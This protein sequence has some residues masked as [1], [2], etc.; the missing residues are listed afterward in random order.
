MTE[1]TTSSLP[2]VTHADYLFYRCSETAA[3]IYYTIL[4]VTIVVVAATF[5][6]EG[7]H[8]GAV[9]ARSI[10]CPLRPHI[11]ATSFREAWTVG[12]LRSKSAH[13]ACIGIKAAAQ[14]GEHDDGTPLGHGCATVQLHH[15]HHHTH[16]RT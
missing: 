1:K 7:M 15:T 3:P 5:R 9:R 2:A 12:T 16:T 14:P 6:R 13:A 8:A 4:S 11:A 10:Q